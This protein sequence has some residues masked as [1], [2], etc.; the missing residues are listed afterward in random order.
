MGN[1]TLGHSLRHHIV[2]LDDLGRD[3]GL[4]APF[5]G[6]RHGYYFGLHPA[7]IAL[8]IGRLRIP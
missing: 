6:Q 7:L 3:F 1:L 8:L 2:R 4:R 5:A